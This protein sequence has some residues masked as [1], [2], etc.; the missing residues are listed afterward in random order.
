[1][2][3]D[4]KSKFENIVKDISYDSQETKINELR[5]LID[6]YELKMK[7]CIE[8]SKEDLIGYA[9]N[10]LKEPYVMD[11]DLA[12]EVLEIMIDKHDCELGIT[13]NTIDYYVRLHRPKEEDD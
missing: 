1:M 13:W 10:N 9:T 8:W 3:S 4:L 7:G 6:E 5:K 11:E 2:Y 12:Q